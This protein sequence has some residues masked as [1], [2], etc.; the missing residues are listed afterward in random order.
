M[1]TRYGDQVVLRSSNGGEYRRNMQ[2]IKPF[3]IADHERAASQSELG[4]ASATASATQ[5]M[6]PITAP[7]PE[8]LMSLPPA[9][10]EIPPEGGTATPSKETGRVS[11][12]PKT[13]SDYVLY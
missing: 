4:S 8:R 10:V 5:V 9:A 13:L 12:R 3:N 6:A 11:R 2:H 7:A 1:M